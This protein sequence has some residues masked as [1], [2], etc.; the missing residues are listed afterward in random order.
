MR[1]VIETSAFYSVHIGDISTDRLKAFASVHK[2]S[3]FLVEYLRR[4]ANRDEEQKSARTY[5]VCDNLTGEL[6]AYF[7]LKAGF[8]ALRETKSLFSQYFDAEPGVELSNFAINGDYIR[9]HPEA[10]G[11]GVNIIKKFVIPVTK[12]AAE[13]IGVRFLYIFALPY[14]S[15]ISHYEDIGFSRLPATQERLIHKRIKPRYDRGCIFM[16]MNL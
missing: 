11:V 5:L 16:Y 7:S 6:V 13:I 2:N 4:Y 12:D 1:K 15:L 10:K 14:D 8:V 9:R 3:G